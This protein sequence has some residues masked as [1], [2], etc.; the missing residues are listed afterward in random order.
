MCGCLASIYKMVKL[1]KQT[2]SRA[3]K[4]N[5]RLFLTATELKELALL[6]FSALSYVGS[7]GD[8]HTY[9]FALLRL[10]K[11]ACVCLCVVWRNACKRQYVARY[12]TTY[13]P[14]SK[15]RTQMHKHTHSL[16]H[17]HTRTCGSSQ[18]A[19]AK[20][21]ANYMRL[22]SR[23]AFSFLA[24]LCSQLFRIASGS[25]VLVVVVIIAT[26]QA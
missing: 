1:A 19:Q 13:R 22:Q 24:L 3:A 2:Q 8:T 23:Q 10:C 9:T 11:G 12:K 18:N 14:Q 20:I 25:A 21:A 4:A 16:T 17:T 5:A 7:G 26:R 15:A 6:L